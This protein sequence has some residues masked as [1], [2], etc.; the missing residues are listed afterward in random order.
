M[1]TFAERQAVQV[2]LAHVFGGALSY[3]N[4][5]AG[6]FGPEA[7][8]ANGALAPF[9]PTNG[10]AAQAVLRY[11]LEARW[12]HQPSLL[13]R[14]LTQLTQN[15]VSDFSSLV[16]RLQR[17]ED[18]NLDPLASSWLSADRPFF[19]RKGSRQCVQGILDS[20]AKPILVVRGE[21]QSGKSYTCDWLDFLAGEQRC[22]FR[23]ISKKLEKKGGPSMDAE[24]LATSIVSKLPQKFTPHGVSQ[25]QNR[26]EERLCNWIVN[27]LLQAPGR[28]WI[29][30]D[31]FGDPDLTPSAQTL[32]QHLAEAVLS[33]TVNRSVRLVLVDF[34]TKLVNVSL[35]RIVNDNLSA[36]SQLQPADLENC[37]AQHFTEIQQEV[38]SE[39]IS[40]L[41]AKLMDKARELKEQEEF[42]A[43]PE[44]E[45]INY[46]LSELRRGGTG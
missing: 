10:E 43:L 6:M 28:T 9:Y 18:P 15:G 39:F 30:L 45:R 26:Y 44:L 37:L 31:G 33:D 23:I 32:I 14:M 8:A 41:S 22:D 16:A 17:K 5:V 46:V 2:A 27:N 35:S 20:S 19:D 25:D 42:K 7:L 11:A 34:P 13:E 4:V 12:Q 36:P 24:F 29:V 3:K 21:D 1:L 40:Q 38:T